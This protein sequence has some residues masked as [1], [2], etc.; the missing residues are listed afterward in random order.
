MRSSVCWVVP[1]IAVLAITAARGQG[2]GPI[3]PEAMVAVPYQPLSWA[4]TDAKSAEYARMLKS[5]RELAEVRDGLAELW[6]R[7]CEADAATGQANVDVL[8]DMREA[9]VTCANQQVRPEPGRAPKWSDMAGRCLDRMYGQVQ[10]FER[11]REDVQILFRRRGDEWMQPEF[12]MLT[13]KF[14]SAFHFKG[15]E[16]V[17]FKWDEKTLAGRFGLASSG[18]DRRYQMHHS[19]EGS[20]ASLPEFRQWKDFSSGYWPDWWLGPRERLGTT[21]DSFSIAAGERRGWLLKAL[22]VAEDRPNAFSSPDQKLFV[23]VEDGRVLRGYAIVQ[24]KL[25]GRGPELLVHLE[26]WLLKDGILEAEFA[27][28]ARGGKRWII[29]ADLPE[30]ES[31]AFAGEYRQVDTRPDPKNKKETIRLEKTGVAEGTLFRAYRGDYEVKGVDGARSGPVLAGVAAARPEV[32]AALPDVSVKADM[33]PGSLFSNVVELASHV[34]ALDWALRE[35]PMPFAE[36]LRCV[37]DGR[38]DRS[39]Y[40]PGYVQ[41]YRKRVAAT[42]S[43]RNAPPTVQPHMHEALAS[44]MGQGAA[45]AAAY[46]ERLVQVARATLADRKAK[47]APAIGI[48]KPVDPDFG[49]YDGPAPAKCE[50]GVNALP[51]GSG[52]GGSNWAVLDDWTCHGFVMRHS[53]FET[54]PYLPELPVRPGLK[55]GGRELEFG[56][57]VRLVH[58]DPGEHLWVWR[59]RPDPVENRVTIPRECLLRAKADDDRRRWG[60]SHGSGVTGET[61]DFLYNVFVT[62]Y[63]TTAIRCDKP[64]RVRMAARIDWDGRVWVNDRLIWRP[65]REHTPDQPA[66]F[67]VDLKAGVNHITVCAS[68]RPAGDG[69]V[70]DQAGRVYK[71]GELAMGSFTVWV[72]A[73]GARPR[74]AEAVAAAREREKAA[75]RKNAETRA[76]RGLRGRRGDGTGIYPDANPPLAW[77]IARGINI[78][79]KTEVATDDAEPVIVGDPST[80]STSSTS[81]RQ[82]GSGQ[83]GSGQGRLFVTTYTGEL[84]CLDA[85]TGAELWRKKPDVQGAALMGDYPPQ[86]IT[87]SFGQSARMWQKDVPATLKPH[88]AYARSCLTVVADARRVWMHDP[89]GV[90][91]C[92]DHDGKQRWAQAVAAQTPRFTEGGYIK[93]R[94]LPLTHPAAIGLRLITATGNGLTAFDMETGKIAWQRPTLDYLGRFAVM[95]PVDGQGNGLVLLSSAEVLDAETGKT[96]ITR[97]A[98]LVPDAACEPVVSGRT[99]YFAACSSGVRFWRNQAGVLCSRVL[100]HTSTDIKRRQHDLNHHNKDDRSEPRFFSKSSA[101]PPTPVLLGDLLIE[102]MGEQMSIDHGPQQSMRL[103]TWDAA[104]GC[105][106]SQCYALQLNATHPV[107]STIIAG[108][109]VFCG[110]E[111]GFGKGDYPGF[112]QEPS[113][114][115]VTAEEQPRRVTRWQPGLATM[116]PPSFRGDCMYLAGEDLVVCV[117]RPKGRADRLTD[118]EVAELRKTLF[119][120]EIGDK[121]AAGGSEV[122]EIATPAG[123]TPGAGVP[124][125]QLQSGKTPNRWM[126]A[127]PFFVEEK[128]DVF[129]ERGGA[130]AALPKVG[131]KVSYT[132]TNGQKDAVTFVVLDPNYSTHDPKKARAKFDNSRHIITAGYARALRNTKL[133]GAINFATAS[134]R[135]YN[136][137]C[138]GYTVIEATEPGSY[139]IDMGAGRIRNSDVYL[140]GRRIEGGMKVRLGP[141]RYPLMVRAAIG[142]CGDWEPIPWAIQF[143][144][145]SSALPPPE[146]LAEPLPSGLR[147]PVS[148]LRLGTLPPRMIGAWPLAL[149][150]KG[151]PYETMTGVRGALIPAGA[152]AAMGGRT[153]TFRPLPAGAIASAGTGRETDTLHFNLDISGNWHYGAGERLGLSE[154]VLFGDTAPAGGLFF[155]VLVNP[156]SLHVEARFEQHVRCWLSGREVRAYE[157]VRLKPGL[158]PFLIEYR[159]KKRHNRPVSPIVFVPVPDRVARADYWVK[160]MD[161]NADILRRIAGSGPNGAYA[162]EALDALDALAG[163]DA[164]G[165][166]DG[167]EVT[168]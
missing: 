154:R 45:G 18:G 60:G 64:R 153:R 42:G 89:R 117:G 82:A 109:Y 116:S 136:T 62:W 134:G 140:A 106:V 96:L 20:T 35:Y 16:D 1:A 3:R 25:P 133:E 63:G 107:T 34:A 141:G 151:N 48:G 142:I 40:Y 52:N 61:L 168:Q 77:D 80:T 160:H 4:G 70:N 123:F 85:G 44:L 164:E 26:R 100:W 93:Q 152:Q 36:A 112:P 27:L 31:G 138:Y 50:Q 161:R 84:V 149:D 39:R 130:G 86:A 155:A 72:A 119:T 103:H 167:L 66:V 57:P 53:S 7:R 74:S 65:A 165:G 94:L 67:P 135:R 43:N 75:D 128:T 9:L 159:M 132:R 12:G 47:S 2:R 148:P 120:L 91:A 147:V 124:V 163:I 87:A 108:G 56:K 68:A 145:L 76:K 131:Q 157:V 118:H 28:G 139:R 8:L 30:A 90:V 49:P 115:I 41:W 11:G 21:T 166:N 114:V 102:H 162:K 88:E 59:A 113:I 17:S 81:S 105:A 158:Y 122:V 101:Y 111:G 33:P 95:E 110:D 55:P 98:P 78:R 51:A 137:T 71:Y 29:K 83:A 144:A 150:G 73:P 129:K 97:C 19:G 58:P 32:K 38:D 24:G 104:T 126:F 5:V 15:C 92:F 146:P 156:R 69:N 121:P 37:R 46:A 10:E 54:G 13:T 127:G 6:R 22:L 14:L 79:W 125:V 23:W 143:V 99:A